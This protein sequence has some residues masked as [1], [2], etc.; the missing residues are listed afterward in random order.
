M[1]VSEAIKLKEGQEVNH[2][3]YG[4]SIVKEVMFSMNSLFGVCIH[5]DNEMGRHKLYADCGSQINDLL[6]DN[7]RNLQRV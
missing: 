6:E 4:K 7:I 3:F 5:I 2:R 1:K